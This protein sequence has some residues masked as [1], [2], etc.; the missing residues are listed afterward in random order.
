MCVLKGV[1][2]QE[3]K[4]NKNGVQFCSKHLGMLGTVGEVLIMWEKGYW[5]K[6]IGTFLL[7]SLLKSVEDGEKYCSAR[8][9]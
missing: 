4:T 6:L 5:K 8:K 7:A 3:I 9:K 2:V 1:C